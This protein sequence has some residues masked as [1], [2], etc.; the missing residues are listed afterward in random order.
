MQ[1]LYPII[2]RKRRTLI[3]ETNADMLKT[4]MLKV[5]RVEAVQAVAAQP[6]VEAAVPI[7][8]AKSSDE[9]V[10]AKRHTR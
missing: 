10:S 6:K 4:E 5:E 8:P 2:R 9:K 1:T 3:V 7:E